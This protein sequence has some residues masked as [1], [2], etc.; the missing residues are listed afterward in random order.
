MSWQL[1]DVEADVDSE[2]DSTGTEA[3]SDW[4]EYVGWEVDKDSGWDSDEPQAA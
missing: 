1:E 3:D 4:E 2:A